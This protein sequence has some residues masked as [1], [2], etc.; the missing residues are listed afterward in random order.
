MAMKEAS[1]PVSDT[2][3]P[4]WRTREWL[5]AVIWVCLLSHMV[6]MQPSRYKY[7][8][9]DLTGRCPGQG[10]LWSWEW[11][12]L[13]ERKWVCRAAARALFSCLPPPATRWRSKV[14]L[15]PGFFGC[16][17]SSQPPE[18]L[19]TLLCVVVYH[20]RHGQSSKVTEASLFFF[21]KSL[22]VRELK[23]KDFCFTNWILLL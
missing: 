7:W 13:C 15:V 10:K 4:P 14:S 6:E 2:L 8:Q 9:V 21:F 20:G 1:Q 5:L 17:Q 3:Q 23:N 12:Y 19:S 11:T 16:T 22:S 18:P